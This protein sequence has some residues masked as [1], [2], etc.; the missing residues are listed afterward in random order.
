MWARTV[1]VLLVVL[2]AGAILT[3]PDT[4]RSLHMN[5]QNLDILK[6]ASAHDDWCPE[7]WLQSR[8]ALECSRPA[9]LLLSC[10]TETYSE[11]GSAAYLGLMVDCSEA[12]ASEPI[13]PI[14][15]FGLGEFFWKSGNADQAISL[16][17]RINCLEY[18]SATATHHWEQGDLRTAGDYWQRVVRIDPGEARGWIGLASIENAYGDFDRAAQFAQRAIKSDP[19]RWEAWEAM[20]TARCGLHDL[21]G[22]VRCARKAI[23]LGSQR[24]QPWNNLAHAYVTLGEL[25]RAEQV[26][27]DGVRRFPDLG[28][29]Y[30][31]L[32]L[33]Q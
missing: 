4:V 26:A 12:T 21:D 31:V 11:R 9:V 17:R 19:A 27:L 32:G 25:V 16:W 24:Y 30:T 1:Q 23:N 22:C 10:P 5:A 29:A 8:P 28:Y 3:A 7:W 6:K 33:V 18:F 15:I 2:A 13:N 14:L 20:A